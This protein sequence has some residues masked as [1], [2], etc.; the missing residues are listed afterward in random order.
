MT[1]TPDYFAPDDAADAQARVPGIVLPP[2]VAKFAV[3]LLCVDMKPAQAAREALPPASTHW[4][5]LASGAR[6]A[7]DGPPSPL[8]IE[9]VASA[10]AKICRFGGATTEFYSVAQH[11]VLVADILRP[12]LRQGGWAWH[13]VDAMVIDALLHDAHEMVIADVVRPA[14]WW[15]PTRGVDMRRY[16]EASHHVDCRIREGLGLYGSPFGDMPKAVKTSDDVALAIERRDLMV[17][18]G[19]VWHGIPTEADIA[20]YPKIVPL[21]WREARD[22]F[23]ARWAEVAA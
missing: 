14:K 11:S 22:L 9:D 19:D 18:T 3:P 10:L 13:L 17:P 15:L 12:L 6:F 2:D 20:G 21:P 1:K 4:L 8:S 16:A 7:L 5:Q 23:L